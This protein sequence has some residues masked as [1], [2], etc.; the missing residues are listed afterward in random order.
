M[1]Y[2]TFLLIFL[3]PPIAALLVALRGR[4]TRRQWATLALIAAIALAY[5]TP[6]DTALVRNGVWSFGPAHIAHL[7]I[8][9]LPMEEY[10]FYVLQV[11]LTGLFTIWWLRRSQPHD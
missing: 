2:L 1:S 5:T 4:V 11:L 10:L 8:G 3:V 6:W 7:V 9:V